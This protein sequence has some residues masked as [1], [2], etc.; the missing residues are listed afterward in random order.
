MATRQGFGGREPLSS[1]PRRPRPRPCAPPGRSPAGDA[2]GWE[3]L[4]CCWGHPSSVHPLT[5]AAGLSIP[6]TGARGL[7]RGRGARA[8]ASVA[9]GGREW[10]AAVGARLMTSQLGCGSAGARTWLQRLWLRPRATLGPE[11]P[12]PSCGAACQSAPSEGTPA[13]CL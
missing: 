1:L 8:A 10:G 13:G 5:A 3:E 11:C 4:H 12:A 7:G 6:K 2:A 9:R